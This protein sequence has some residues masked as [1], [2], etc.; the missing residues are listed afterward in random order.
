MCL[1]NIK[2]CTEG[3]VLGQLFSYK[4][5]VQCVC[6]KQCI[7]C[8]NWKALQALHFNVF[9][10]LSTLTIHVVVTLLLAVSQHMYM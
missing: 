4:L 3:A 5:H 2:L 10:D 1:D 9:H 7:G 6:V 8:S